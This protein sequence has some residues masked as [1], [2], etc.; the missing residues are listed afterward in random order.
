M[1]YKYCLFAL[2]IIGFEQPNG[3]GDVYVATIAGVSRFENDGQLLQTAFRDLNL[4]HLA[5]DGADE[6]FLYGNRKD[7]ISGRHVFGIWSYNFLTDELSLRAR[8]DQLPSDFTVGPDGN[9]YKS[10]IDWGTIRVYD[11]K[12]NNIREIVLSDAVTNSIAFGRD[13]QLY[14]STRPNVSGP[15]GGIPDIRR[16][17]SNSDMN[18]PADVVR[19]TTVESILVGNP[20]GDLFVGSFDNN[21]RFFV[22]W[23]PTTGQFSENKYPVSGIYIGMSFDEAGNL[24]YADT[25]TGAIKKVDVSGTTFTF[26]KSPR[27]VLDIVHVPMVP[28]RALATSIDTSE[29]DQGIRTIHAGTATRGFDRNLD[30]KLDQ[31]DLVWFVQDH[32]L[33]VGDVDFDRDLDSSDLIA[34]FQ[35]GQYEDGVY[36]NSSWITGD[37]T[38]DREFD[39]ADLTLAFAAGSYE[40]VTRIAVGV[41]EPGG[42]S[43]MFLFSIRWLIR[44]RR[45]SRKGGCSS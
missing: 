13:G 19:T 27:P 38:G 5:W 18:Q 39:S 14:A 3:Y 7:M 43:I 20:K 35:V 34:V 1:F 45:E 42:S 26:A 28:R 11:E 17:N 31:T 25:F 40:S 36:A 21:G 22:K 16:L 9:I 44:R 32:Q 30:G 37:W 4:S 6:L 12:G 10:A 15:P 41:P 2:V 33:T 8:D 23:D 29:L 24:F